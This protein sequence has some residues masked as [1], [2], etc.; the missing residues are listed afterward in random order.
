MTPSSNGFFAPSLHKIYPRQ[1]AEA[2]RTGP[3]HMPHFG[4]GNLSNQQ[5]ADIVRYVTAPI[6]HPDNHGGLGLGGI[7]PVAEGFIGLLFG[8]GGHHAR[9]V[10]ARGPQMSDDVDRRS[11]RS[12]RATAPPAGV[13]VTKF[14]DPHLQPFAKNPRRAEMLIG[15]LLLLGLAGFCAYGALYWVGGQ[16]QWEGVFGGVGF[17]AFGFGLSAWG[18]YLLP[19]GPFVE[20][21]HDARVDRARDRGHGGRHRGPGQDGVPPAG[22][23]GHD[24]RRRR[25]A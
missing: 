20:E 16:T 15:L 18:K 2:I 10:L 13:P 23:S 24:P 3:T 9:G 22:L 19:Q 25:R 17:F 11:P 6:Q 14:D 7:G 8:V 21:R 4:P 1:I 12:P 5:V